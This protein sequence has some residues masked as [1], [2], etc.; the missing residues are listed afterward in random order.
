MD[1]NRQ[2]PL[3]ITSQEKGGKSIFN[4]TIELDF[5]DL[6]NFQI[7]KIALILYRKKKILLSS[8]LW[9]N[10]RKKHNND[11]GCLSEMENFSSLQI[12]SEK[13]L[14]SLGPHVK[15]LVR[16]CQL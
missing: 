5:L 4:I 1:Y 7:I 13:A 3:N 10:K 14:E 12:F 9:I 6:Y 15:I 8:R 2:C 16:P 11:N